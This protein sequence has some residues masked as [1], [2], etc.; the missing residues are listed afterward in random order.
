[1]PENFSRPQMEEILRSVDLGGRA[2]DFLD[3]LNE[4]EESFRGKAWSK[5]CKN[6]SSAELY[7][8]NSV[9]V[10]IGLLKDY[11]TEV[12]NNGKIAD[13]EVG[14]LGKNDN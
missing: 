6:L 7:S 4:F 8:L 12:V 11:I 10:T 1:M 14:E 13:M 3:W 5:M 9:A 2:E